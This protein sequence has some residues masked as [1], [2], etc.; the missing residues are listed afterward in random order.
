[1]SNPVTLK[2]KAS[3]I[4]RAEREDNKKFFDVFTELGEGTPSFATLLFMLKA[5]GATEDEA[6]QLIDEK[7]VGE[8]LI[9]A[10][11]ALADSGFLGEVKIDTAEMRQALVKAQN[12]ASS[13]IG[14]TKKA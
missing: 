7:G 9:L 3:T 11:E 1:M 13:D 10:V 5:G 12:E 2:Y 4:A 6:D 14:E 8:S